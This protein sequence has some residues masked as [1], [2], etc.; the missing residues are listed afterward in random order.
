[1]RRGTGFAAALVMGVAALAGCERGKELPKEVVSPG[2][3]ATPPEPPTPTASQPEAAKVVERAIKAA[4]EGH[5]ERIGKLKTSRAAMK[6]VVIINT[7]PVNWNRR[8]EA[9]W[10][11]RFFQSDEFNQNG[12]V[13]V[14]IGD[15]NHS[16]WVRNRRGSRTEPWEP[17]DP[18]KFEEANAAD[19]VGRYWMPLLVP[20]TDPR[21]IVFDAR[22]QTIHLPTGAMHFDVIKAAVPNRPVYTLWFEEQTGFLA[23]V[24][25]NHLEPLTS[26]PKAKTF[27]LLMHRPF[28]GGVVLPGKIGYEEG[29]IV[30][31]EWRVDSWEAVP[32]IDDATFEPP[33]K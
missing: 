10:P 17:P 2:E 19:M 26:V 29:G 13:Q 31:E 24:N 6:G 28:P 5:P 8:I 27:N 14:M 30:R 16:M 11:D 23:R 20:L 32:N 25:F 21:T 7:V 33:A 12:P 15:R 9:I 4:T 22:K 18:V 1:M 3:Q